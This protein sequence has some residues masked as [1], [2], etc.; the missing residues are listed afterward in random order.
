M[1]LPEAMLMSAICAAAN[2]HDGT[3][4]SAVAGSYVDA[5]ITTEEHSGDRAP[6]CHLGPYQCLWP[7]L[8][9]NP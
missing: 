1:Q 8:S 7:V 6:G 9:Q 2:G 4:G 3:H 5:H